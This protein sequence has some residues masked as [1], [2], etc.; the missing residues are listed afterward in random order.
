MD[1]NN[2]KSDIKKQIQTCSIK[3]QSNKNG[4]ENTITQIF[5]DFKVNST[6]Q[7]IEKFIDAIDFFSTHK[8]KTVTKITET[9]IIDR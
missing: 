7:Q 4:E 6:N 1:K 9:V 8:T 3:V 2:T 5:R